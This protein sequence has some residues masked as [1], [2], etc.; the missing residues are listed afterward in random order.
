VKE[1]MS[2]LA[3]KRLSAVV[4]SRLQ[5]RPVSAIRTW[6]KLASVIGLAKVDSEHASVAACRGQSEL[7]GVASRVVREG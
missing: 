4:E 3:Q 2:A 1:C 5:V 7:V 6:R